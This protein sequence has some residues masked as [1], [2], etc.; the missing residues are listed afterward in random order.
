MPV[1][2]FINGG[3][4]DSFARYAAAFRKGLGETGYVEGQNV[5]VEYRWLKRRFDRL[6]AVLDDL[7]RRRVAVI[8]TPGAAAAR[9]PPER[10]R[11][12]ASTQQS[13]SLRR[14]AVR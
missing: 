12:T 1:I 4:A 11:S 13:A 6:A 14:Y 9:K 10:L 3:S 5:G 7:L 2:G 8:A